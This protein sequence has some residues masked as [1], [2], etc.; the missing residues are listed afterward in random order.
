[1][2]Y[3]LW[4]AVGG[5]AVMVSAAL[6]VGLATTPTAQAA[7]LRITGEPRGGPEISNS[8]YEG[9]FAGFVTPS[10]SVTSAS[11]RVT[12]PTVKCPSSGTA[13]L[14][15]SI[16]IYSSAD[17][18]AELFVLETCSNGSAKYQATTGVTK[19]GGDSTY[20]EVPFGISPGNVVSGLATVSS[21]G[22]L[23][24]ATTNITTKKSF[25]QSGTTTAGGSYYAV[26]YNQNSLPEP[27]PAFKSF[28]WSMVDVNAKP[29]A[30]TNPSRYDMTDKA[31]KHLM[32]RT[33]PLSSSGTSFT[34]T[35]VATS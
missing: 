1:M 30:D 21:K 12:V 2:A 7:G 18:G 27:I 22:A 33:S 3:R 34:N 19:K 15:Q 32:V 31:N 26:A 5:A 29:I 4:S 24:V 28:G 16:Q 13:F 8:F 20:K 14:N 9:S 11:G 23:K 6:S 17:E 10:G 25:F 35:F